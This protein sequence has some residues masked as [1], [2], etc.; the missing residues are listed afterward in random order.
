MNL[1]DIR[2]KQSGLCEKY[3]CSVEEMKE[4]FWMKAVEMPVFCS[5]VQY[6]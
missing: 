1:D 2:I 5:M 3:K 6:G 4:L